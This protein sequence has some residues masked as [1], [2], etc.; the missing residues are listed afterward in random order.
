MKA[1]QKE[2]MAPQAYCDQVAQVF[3]NLS[4]ECNISP[5]S[6]NRTTDFHHREKVLHLWERLDRNGALYKGEHIGWYCTSEETFYPESRLKTMITD[7]AEKRFTVEGGKE[8]ELVSE[9][10]FKFRLSDYIPQV[11]SWLENMSPIVPKSRLNDLCEVLEEGLPDLS[12]SRSAK[13]NPWGISVP[14]DPS[15]TIYVWLDALSNYL[16]KDSEGLWRA[17]DVHVIG[18][19]ILKFHAIYWPAFLMAADLPLP[20]KLV[21]HGHW[22]LGKQKMSKSLGNVVNPF[23]DLKLLG[24]DSFRYLLLR[25][26][27]VDA[28]SDYS[29]DVLVKRY[30]LEL[31][32]VIGNLVSRLCNSVFYAE[33]Q[34]FGPQDLHSQSFD[35]FRVLKNRIENHYDECK[36]HIGVEEILARLSEINARVNE[37]KPWVLAKDANFDELEKLMPS[38]LFDTFA[39]I[40][41]LYPIMPKFTRNLMDLVKLDITG[42]T[43]DVSAYLKHP[44][45]SFPRI[46]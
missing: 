33:K 30:N 44:S 2:K 16:S 1:A 41:L 38:I 9:T 8:V 6:F 22:N 20:K 29:K 7:G 37:V 39:T 45:T 46:K 18:K 28:D 26:S 43:F 34:N 11:R 31:A 14:T 5:F 12:V 10:N 24:I 19:D 35:S 21:T 23:D 27:R 25:L 13:S 40:S 32:N 42:R 4:E 15:Q 36:F 3:K 17:P